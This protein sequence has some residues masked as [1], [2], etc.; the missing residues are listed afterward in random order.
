MPHITLPPNLPGIAGPL[1]FKPA[2]GEKFNAFTEELMRGPSPLTQGER[3]LIASYVSAGNECY[4]CTNS[5]A[6]AARH[7][8]PDDGS[9]FAAVCTNVETAPV[10]ELL[11]ALLVIADKVRTSGKD[12]T[13]ED[14]ARARAAG[15]D[16][17]ALHDTVLIAAAFCMANRYV[18]GLD[19]VAPHDDAMYDQ[20]GKRLANEGYLRV[21]KP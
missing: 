1:A 7:A 11:R 16:D 17:E 18:E 14:V 19:T 6:A 4:F 5:H 10:S 2:L 12:V 9:T 20:A 13:A 15:A 8:L 21:L 3:E